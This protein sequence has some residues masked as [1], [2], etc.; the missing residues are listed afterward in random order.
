LAEVN[1]RVANSLAMV[2][3]LVKLQSRA[4]NEPSARSALAE[5]EAR[6]NAVASV[7]KRLYTSGNVQSVPLNEYMSGILDNLA[8]VMRD[9]G[10]RSKL[11]YDLDPLEL[12]TDASVNLG[13]ITTEWVTNAFKYAYPERGGE[14]RVQLRRLPN[15]RGELVVEDS[16]VG[17]SHAGEPKGTGLGTRIVR[18]MADSISGSIEYRD[19]EP[20][21]AARIVFPLRA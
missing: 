6:I 16:G 10:L 20:G 8:G 9:Q 11:V 12:Q 5:T 2:S 19:R 21:T 15:D 17:R 3:S 4:V 1:H 14:I 13:V 7:H 18:A